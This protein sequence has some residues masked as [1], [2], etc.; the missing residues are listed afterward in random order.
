[1]YVYVAMCVNSKKRNTELLI[2][3]KI[4]NN[5]N[6]SLCQQNEILCKDTKMHK[7]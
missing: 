6:E 3:I 1:M 5:Q 4:N 7:K 2:Y